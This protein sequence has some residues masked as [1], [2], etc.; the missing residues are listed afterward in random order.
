MDAP[1]PP[2]LP[3]PLL[4]TRVMFRRCCHD[5]VSGSPVVWLGVLSLLLQYELVCSSPLE[6]LGGRGLLCPRR[7]NSG[8][9]RKVACMVLSPFLVGFFTSSVAG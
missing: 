2:P 1:P 4:L 5:A 9:Q 8:W 7:R 3:L 6:I